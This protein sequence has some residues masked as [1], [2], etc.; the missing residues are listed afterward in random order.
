MGSASSFGV[1]SAVLVAVG[2]FLGSTSRYLIGLFQPGL[3]GTL[4]VNVLG[5]FLLGV[6]VYESLGPDLLDDLSRR[7]LATGV[8]SSFTTYSTFA[9]ESVQ[10][11]PTL[12]AANVIASYGLGF[13]GVLVGRGIAGH[14]GALR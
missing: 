12:G 5:S 10:A 13:L 7:V 2:G 1:Q 6:I 11:G 3:P 14:L 4:V 9:L 8:L